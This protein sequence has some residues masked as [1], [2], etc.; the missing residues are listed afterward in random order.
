MKRG[1]GTQRL[2]QPIRGLASRFAYAGLVAVAIGLMVLGKIDVLMTDSFRAQ[3]TDAVAPVLDALSRPAEAMNRAVDQVRE[4]SQLRQENAR[5]RDNQGRLLQWQTAARNLEAENK[6][7]RELLNFKTGPEPSFIT[8]RVIADT[9]G[10]FA[11]SLILNAGSREGVVRGQA[12]VTGLGLAGRVAGVGARSARILLVTD[13]N[14]RIPV[15]VGDTRTRAIMAG[16][17]TNQ[18]K[19]IHLPSGESVQIGDRVVTSGHG[20]ALPPGLPVGQ[21]TMV[22][23]NGIKVRPFVERT[24]LEFIRLLDFGL[25][26]ILEGP[27]LRKAPKARKGSR[28]RKP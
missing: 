8:A 2:S 5:L 4:L 25:A 14:S 26:G 7:L 6:A 17:N 18:P 3:V 24:R 28:K 20:G 27:T 23:E 13:L 22:N 19:L 15:V 9:G 10:A 11:H 21:V 1:P 16:N 12:A